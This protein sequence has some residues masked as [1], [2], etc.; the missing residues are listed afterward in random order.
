MISPL[1]L[2]EISAGKKVPL[3]TIER[4]YAQGW[5]LSALGDSNLVLKGGTAIRK[6]YIQDYRYSDDLDFTL[7]KD[8]DGKEIYKDILD[9]IHTA[10][11]NSGIQFIDDLQLNENRNGFVGKVYFRLHRYGST[12]IR[13]KIDITRKESEPIIM[14]PLM[15]PLIHTYSDDPG[16][17]VLVYSIEEIFTE[18]IRSLFQRTRPRDL[19]DVS[20]LSEFVDPERV[21]DLVP[22]KFT[23]KDIP[24]DIKDLNERKDNFLKAWNSSLSHQIADLP[25]PERI[26]SDVIMKLKIYFEGGALHG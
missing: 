25:S 16:S 5:F 23:Q 10:K 8:L 15:K 13:I 6:V 7:F 18:K 12:P 2:N 1:E 17:M 26:W 24:P 19:Y 22:I 3:T 11:E 21:H 14:P 9:T 4:D 20:Q